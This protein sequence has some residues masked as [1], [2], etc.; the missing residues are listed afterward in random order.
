ML[1]NTSVSCLTYH[2]DLHSLLTLVK[3]D[4]GEPA[5]SEPLCRSFE[6]NV[7]ILSKQKFSSNVIEKVM[8][9]TPRFA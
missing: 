5:F 3:V 6:D 7:A 9:F 8:T 2:V 4:L 1:F